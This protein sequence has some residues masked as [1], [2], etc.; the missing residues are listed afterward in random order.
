MDQT[1][2]T[3][4]RQ[5]RLQNGYSLRELARRIELSPNFL[6]NMEGGHLPPPCEQ[7]IV[8]IAKTLDQ[9]PDELLE[10]VRSSPGIRS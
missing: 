5:L 6:S 2:G 8:L 1:F 7:K 9:N 10:G 3:L 4:V